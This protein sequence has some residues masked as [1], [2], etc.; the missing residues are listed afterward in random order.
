MCCELTSLF[1]HS[2]GNVR[3]ELRLLWAPL[4]SVGKEKTHLLV[5]WVPVSPLKRINMGLCSTTTTK[6]F[7]PLMNFVFLWWIFGRWQTSPAIYPVQEMNLMVS[8]LDALFV[9]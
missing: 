5:A 4:I 9:N 6:S 7:M 8:S 3:E 2:S 1:I